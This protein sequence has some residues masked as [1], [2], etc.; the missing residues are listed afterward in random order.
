MAPKK[1]TKQTRLQT[2]AAQSNKV[3]TGPKG[4]K[5]QSTTNK[6]LLRQGN[7]PTM[8]GPKRGGGVSKPATPAKVT[9][10]GGGGTPQRALPPA[11]GTSGR[12]ASSRRAAAEAKAKQAAQG[13][14]SNVLRSR[15]P[16]TPPPK[17]AGPS[18]TARAAQ[19][20]RGMADRAGA[21]AGPAIRNLARGLASKG[22]V[23]GALK[24][25]LTAAN[26]GKF[27]TPVGAAIAVGE[28]ARYGVSKEEVKRT[29]AA[30]TFKQTNLRGGKSAKDMD[31][32]AAASAAA[33]GSTS[34]FK[35]AREAAVRKAAAIKGS[36]VVGSGK[37]K[38][39]SGSSASNFDSAFAAARKAGKSTFTWKGKKYTTQMK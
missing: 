31:R 12:P 11:G 9:T 35:G 2:K 24:G 30:G 32:K 7:K 16:A 29:K 21:Q 6:Q 38:S 23:K 25:A 8:S 19:A 36:P 1:P 10:G 13:T 27:A 37:A 17:A 4:S 5:P 28:L 34:K 15:G 26:V 33:A 39:A 3:M 22:A 14:R 20:G 18:M